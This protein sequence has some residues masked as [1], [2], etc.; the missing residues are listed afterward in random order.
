VTTVPTAGRLSIRQAHNTYLVASQHPA[1][2]RLRDRLDAAMTKELAPI[3][4]TRLAAWFANAGPGLWLIR[5]LE[6]TVDVNAAWEQEAIARTWARAMVHELSILLQDAGDGVNALWFPGRAA[7]LARFLV[8]VAEECAWSKWYYEAFAGL[9]PLPTSAVLRTAICEQ[10]ALGQAALLH[11]SAV[12]LKQ[13]LRALTLH[14]ARRILDSLAEHAP[15]GGEFDGFQAVWSAWPAVP[16]EDRQGY[17]PPTDDWRSALRLYLEA[18]RRAEQVG[19]VPLRTATLAILRLAWC[20]ATPARTVGFPAP[21]RP[22]PPAAGS[23]ALYG[24]AG[25]PGQGLLALLSRSDRAGLYSAVGPAAGC[26]P[27]RND[28]VRRWSGT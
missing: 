13:V 3:L 9:R 18:S 16:E 2:E 4:A 21:D 5:R 23:A 24:D 26:S 17:R 11:L 28:P 8:D 6:L 7:Y 19:G 1:P 12:E 25:S 15:L 10:P 27:R 20:L 22:P 14:D